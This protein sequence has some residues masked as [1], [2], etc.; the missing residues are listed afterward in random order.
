MKY[1][2]ILIS[3]ASFVIIVAGLSAA[4]SIVV[5]FLL[6]VFIAIIV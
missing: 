6:A 4:S 1:Q 3:I 5:P 2:L